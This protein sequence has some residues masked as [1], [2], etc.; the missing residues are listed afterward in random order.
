MSDSAASSVPVKKVKFPIGVK[1]ALIL[2]VIILVSLGSV[3]ALS[4]IL[5]GEDV[6]RTAEQSNFDIN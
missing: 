1:L 4:S 5:M 3:T 2:G 6:R